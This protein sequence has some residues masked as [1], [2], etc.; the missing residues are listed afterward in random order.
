MG[1]QDSKDNNNAAT[2]VEA[3]NVNE[4][5]NANTNVHQQALNIAVTINNNHITASTKPQNNNTVELSEEATKYQHYLK[6]LY[7]NNFVSLTYDDLCAFIVQY[8]WRRFY[9]EKL[10]KQ[11]KGIIDVIYSSLETN[12]NVASHQNQ[13]FNILD[14]KRYRYRCY[15]LMKY[16]QLAK[17]LNEVQ[18]KVLPAI[19]IN[20]FYIGG[21]DK[22]QE[23]EDLKL[24][25][26]IINQEYN[27]TCLQCHIARNDND[28]DINVCPY[29][30]KKY[31]FFTEQEEQRYDVFARRHSG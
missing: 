26:R 20:G 23:L 4:N 10:R 2:A 3:V 25:H 30:Y 7:K 28:S 27:D 18:S 31:L 1:N 15:D 21:F 19:F 6:F 16:K 8:H 14:T 22:L 24:I 9:I 11:R 13:T 5:T 29:C 17:V 12:P